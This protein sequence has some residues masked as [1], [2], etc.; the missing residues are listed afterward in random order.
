MAKTLANNIT[1]ETQAPHSF[2]IY[3]SDSPMDEGEV[4]GG[5]NTPFHIVIGKMANKIAYAKLLI[6][7]GEIALQDFPISN[8]DHY[9]PG[10]FITIKMGDI[11]GLETVF[12]GMI[13]KHGIKIKKNR[14]LHLMI[15]CRDN[16]VATTTQTKSKYFAENTLDSDAFK[17]LLSE[18]KKGKDPLI[19]ATGIQLIGIL[20][21]NEQMPP[22]NWCIQTME[23]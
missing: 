13:V 10:R 9:A 22:V 17:E 16:A 21:S 15:D 23:F 5:G 11:D 2:E 6:E 19:D 18:Y 20:L 7:D 1:K 12:K 3:L 8:E 14:K 4:V